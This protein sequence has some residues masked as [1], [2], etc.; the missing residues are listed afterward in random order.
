M[1]CGSFVPFS[2]TKI[3]NTF[4]KRNEL[5]L[6]QICTRDLRGKDMNSSTLGSRGQGYTRP[7]IDLETWRKQHSRLLRW[8]RFL[9]RDAMHR[10]DCR[11][12]M[13]GCPSVCLSVCH[14]RRYS[15]ETAKYIVKTFSPSGSHVIRGAKT[16]CCRSYPQRSTR[17]LRF[18]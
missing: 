8:I 14:T 2:V 11:R 12:K 16:W 5:I 4:W 18:T 9:P 1:Y 13:S 3:V 6:M 15:V 10:V 17:Y 7:K